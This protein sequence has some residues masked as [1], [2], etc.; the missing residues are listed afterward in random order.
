MSL[1]ETRQKAAEIETRIR[2][3]KWK[4]VLNVICLIVCIAMMIVQLVILFS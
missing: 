2:V 1:E 3:L 4:I